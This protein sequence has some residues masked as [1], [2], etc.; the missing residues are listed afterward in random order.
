MD[1]I[2]APLSPFMRPVLNMFSDYVDEDDDYDYE[3]EGIDPIY[4]VI[5]FFTLGIWLV[6]KRYESIRNRPVHISWPAP[7]V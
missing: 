6:F 2:L 4:I 5:A 3:E 1:F 7:E